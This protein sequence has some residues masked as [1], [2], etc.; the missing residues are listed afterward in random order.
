MGVN[1]AKLPRAV[2][3]RISD[4][5]TSESTFPSGFRTFRNVT[6]SPF[7]RAELQRRRLSGCPCTRFSHRGGQDVREAESVQECGTRR[8]AQIPLCLNV[9]DLGADVSAEDGVTDLVQKDVEFA[10]PSG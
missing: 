2:S 9:L 6:T 1:A 3:S 4:C 10:T 5:W 7:I 8:P